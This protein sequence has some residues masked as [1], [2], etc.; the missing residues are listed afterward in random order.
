MDF[1]T[2]MSLRCKQ[3]SAVNFSRSGAASYLTCRKTTGRVQSTQKPRNG[4]LGSKQQIFEQWRKVVEKERWGEV[5]VACSCQALSSAEHPSPPCRCKIQE[6]AAVLFRILWKF[7]SPPLLPSALCLCAWFQA[8]SLFHVHMHIQGFAARIFKG[9]GAFTR[10]G[11]QHCSSEEN[12]QD[13][14]TLYTR[15][16]GK[17]NNPLNVFMPQ[18]W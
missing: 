6:A 1:Q 5:A 14:K 13:S 4:I 17:V 3:N 16:W 2:R 10:W 11:G 12:T 15:I 9:T 8:L 18:W 7:F